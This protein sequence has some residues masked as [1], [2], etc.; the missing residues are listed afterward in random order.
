M[1]GQN[2]DTKILERTNLP[3]VFTMLKLIQLQEDVGGMSSKT[4]PGHVELLHCR[5]K[6]QPDL[7]GDLSRG[8][9]GLRNTVKQ[10]S[11][12]YKSVTIENAIIGLVGHL[13]VHRHSAHVN[14]LNHSIKGTGRL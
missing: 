1:A 14:K 13:R 6:H 7:L 10:G 11:N 12:T 4:R 8:P 5:L 3:G 9:R 2:P